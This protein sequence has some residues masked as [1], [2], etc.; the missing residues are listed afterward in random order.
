MGK[1]IQKVSLKNLSTKI[2]D[3]GYVGENEHSIIQIDCSEVLWDYPDA[4]ADM[5][6]QPPTGDMYPV[7]P[8]LDEDLLIWE[9]TDS[10]LV[11]AGTGR[12][13][14]TFKNGDEVVKSAIGNTKIEPSIMATG[15]PPTPLENWMERAEETAQQIAEDAADAAAESILSDYAN[16]ADDV[17]DLKTAISQ[18][19]KNLFDMNWLLEADGWTKNNDEYYGTAQAMYDKYKASVMPF[20]FASFK[21][22]TQYTFSFTVKV[23]GSVATSQCFRLAITYTDGTVTNILGATNSWSNFTYNSDTSDAG[24]TISKVNVTYGNGLGNTLYIKEMQCEEGT[25]ATTYVPHRTAT[26]FIARNMIAEEKT[27]ILTQLT[28]PSGGMAYHGEKI[29]LSGNTYN[30]E[31]KNI[32]IGQGQDCLAV[33][34]YALGFSANDGSCKI[35]NLSTGQQEALIVMPSVDGFTPHFNT[36]VFGET[37]EGESIPLLYANVCTPIG[38][39]VVPGLCAVYQISNNNNTWSATLINTITVSF[40]GDAEWG[41]LSVYDAVGFAVDNG[42]LW[43]FGASKASN[44][45][46]FVAFNLQGHETNIVLSRADIVKCFSTPYLPVIQGCDIYNGKIFIIEGLGAVNN[47]ASAFYV[48]DLNVCAIVSYINLTQTFSGEPEFVFVYNG[49]IYLGPWDLMKL[50]V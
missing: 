42:K 1:R 26:D 29:S 9:I 27:N 16:L 10:D 14:L 43:V 18:T 4:T 23:S 46:N 47:G 37:L 5:V 6:V 2:L 33:N 45:T 11:Y 49:S 17:T 7:T 44:K 36:V 39:S 31:P 34:G 3:I 30:L 22:N 48:V 19:T 20:P 25:V 40:V 38:D 15:D 21:E 35:T 24:K 32:R 8:D 28:G 13:Q 12:F 50:I 41:T